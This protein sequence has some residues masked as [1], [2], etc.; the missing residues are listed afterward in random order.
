MVAS[1]TLTEH[2]LGEFDQL[3]RQPEVLAW[4]RV[5]RSTHDLI[6]AVRTHH[7]TTLSRLL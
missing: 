2:G 4:R 3:E 5:M 6:L 7:R 1:E